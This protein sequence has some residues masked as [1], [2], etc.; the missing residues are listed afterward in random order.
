M[1]A[2]QT[3]EITE[4][5]AR[6][7]LTEGYG[8][9]EVFYNPKMNLNRDIAMLF[10]R[11]HFPVWR[12]LRICDPMTASAVRAVRY[13][14]EAPNVTSVIAADANPKSV[15]SAARMIE[16]NDVGDKVSVVQEEAN[17]LLIS[18]MMD[19]FDLIDLDPYGSPAPFFEN[20]LRAT[21]DGGVIAASATDMAPLTGT[22]S[23]ACFR[24][25]GI[26]PVRTEFEKE[27]AVRTL[28][29]NLAIVAGKLQLGVT[30]AFS[31]AS[32]H[33]V[34]IYADVMKGKK[35]ANES[36]KFLEF[37]KYCPGCLKRTHHSS[38]D[39]IEPVCDCGSKVR[40]GGPFWFGPLWNIS[41]IDRMSES[42]LMIE[43]SRLSELQNLLDRIRGEA[44]APALYYR[45]DF[46]SHVL[47]I[48]PPKIS[49]VLTTLQEKKFS[50]VRTH[51]HPNGFRTDAPH[52]EVVSVVRALVA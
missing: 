47:R 50:A 43:S 49:D 15:Q 19:R 24:K 28:A 52:Q 16:L 18:H 29:A 8:K 13:V 5:K 39:Q 38:L 26:T 23:A 25:Y 10:A 51:F 46:L 48:R 22:R 34:R 21:I 20:T 7:L 30:L 4:G 2:S 44:E 9:Q 17:V 11:S 12:H 31:H 1:S 42:C 45:V 14:L 33:Y 6:L 40:V 37:L 27:M 36:M 41:T 3:V 32:D 35:A